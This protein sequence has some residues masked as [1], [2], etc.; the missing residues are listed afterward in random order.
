M[1]WKTKVNNQTGLA[2][3][4]QALAFL[5][6]QGLRLRERNYACKAGELDLVMND[7]DTLVF[8]EVRFRKSDNYG[9]AEESVTHRKQARLNRAAAHYMQTFRL[10]DK[11]PCR[12][13]IITIHPDRNRDGNQV[14]WIRNAFGP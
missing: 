1:F 12:F 10:T 13:D 3:E 6:K 11:V 8:I 5:Q 9:S 2:A 14:N 7:K 4:N